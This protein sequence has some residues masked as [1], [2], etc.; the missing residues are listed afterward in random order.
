MPPPALLAADT[1]QPTHGAAPP[2]HSRVTGEGAGILCNI[3]VLVFCW[4]DGRLRWVRTT[5]SLNWQFY[6]L[7]LFLIFIY[8]SSGESILLRW[9]ILSTVVYIMA[10]YQ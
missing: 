7:A 8:F 4:K 10:A 3:V 5:H 9:V 1:R 6:E 2:P